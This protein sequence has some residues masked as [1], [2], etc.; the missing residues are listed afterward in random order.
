MEDGPE[1]QN[2]DEN[3][4]SCDKAV[5]SMAC[6][7]IQAQYASFDTTFLFQMQLIC[8][9]FSF[10]LRQLTLMATAAFRMLL[11][12]QWCYFDAQNAKEFHEILS[13]ILNDVI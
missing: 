12:R 6:A 9:I 3:G 11:I 4:I 13:A 2:M 1:K 8:Q 5:I 10:N 7:I